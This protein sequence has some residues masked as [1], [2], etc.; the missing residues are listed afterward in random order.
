MEKISWNL[1]CTFKYGFSIVLCQK[2]KKKKKKVFSDFKKKEYSKNLK[3][4]GKKI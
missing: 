2:K 3:G 1:K 4:E